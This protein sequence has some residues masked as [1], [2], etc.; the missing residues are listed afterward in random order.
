MR[1]HFDEAGTKRPFCVVP[2]RAA[3]SKVLNETDLRVLIAL[4]YH[5]NRA[6]VCWPSVRSLADTA[7]VEPNTV[8]ASIK[9]LIKHKM[10]R[11]LNPNDY[12]QREGQ[13]GFSNR[14]QVMWTPDAP[15]PTYEEILSANLLQPLADRLPVETEGS[16]ARGTAETILHSHTL[17]AAF[18]QTV[19]RL[20]GVRPVDVSLPVALDLAEAGATVAEIIELTEQI[21]RRLIADR[22][23]VVTLIEVQ[24]GRTNT[25]RSLGICTTPGTGD[26]IGPP[27]PPPQE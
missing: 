17:V 21:Q 16:G 26:L 23:G 2:V 10:V 8:Q 18:R 27:P 13:W 14:Y 25:K 1:S 15:V 3:G 24:Q 11:Q 22:R 9:R 20:T 4:G 7:G 5:T 19:E 12:D 6:G